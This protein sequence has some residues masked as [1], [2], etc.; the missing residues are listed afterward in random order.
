MQR[1]FM[2]VII[3]SSANDVAGREGGGGGVGDFETSGVTRVILTNKQ[4]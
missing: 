3:I 4:P 1:L 2:H